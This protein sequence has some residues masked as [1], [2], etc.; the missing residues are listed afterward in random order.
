MTRYFFNISGLLLILALL[1]TACSPAPEVPSQYDPSELQFSG[2]RAYEIEEEFVTTHINRVSGSEESRLAV[3]W[4]HDQLTDSGWICEVDEWETVLYSETVELRNVVCRLPGASD[5]EILV[6]AHHDI[7]P[8]TVQGAD[9]DGSGVAILL[10][11]AEIFA[12]E[13]TPQ[14]TLVFVADDAEEFGMIG[15]R[16]YV[17]THPNPEKIIAG[18]SLDNLGR[19]YY[20]DMHTDLIGQYEGYAPIWIGLTAREAAQAAGADWE[21]ILKG[22]IDQVLNQAITISFT[23]Q[24]PINA[25]GV[26]AIGFSAGVPAEF[27]DI[28]YECWH[29]PCDNM[30]FQNP[31]SLEQ[32]GIITEALIRQLLA[33]ET[34]PEGSGP[35]LYFDGSGQMFS[36]FPLYLIFI[37]FVS[38]FFVGSYFTHRESLA[39]KSRGW[40]KALP[41]FLGLWLP[42]VASILLL[43]LFVAVGIM[44]EFTSYPGTTKD[45]TQL[46][47]SWLAVILF[48]IGV[49]VFFIIGRWLVGRFAGD[50]TT[51]EFGFTKS[52][53]FLIIGLISLVILIIDPFAL[54]FFIP[55]L[56]WFLIRGR[57]GAGKILDVVFFLLGGL[58]IYALIYFFGFMILR[59]EFVFLWYFMS[60]ISTGMFSFVDVASGAAVMAAG[61]SM[62]V[63]PPYRT[64]LE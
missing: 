6:L 47:P 27:S 42:L 20:E 21:V 16:R 34:F 10:H 63:K 49:G 62:I 46:N 14:Y 60:A 56:F 58:M 64:K 12:A 35:Y 37:G 9:N 54:I 59:Y 19:T 17:E 11:L 4:L 50:A 30:D 3:E 61:L 2:E 23:D 29:H 7:A 39:E 33:M 38:I 43:Y 15:S 41:H 13:G 36:G 5:Q 22:P 31:A 45:L 51:P 1:I 52:L 8:T 24:G 53:A 28:H 57:S 32:S 25:A 26:P 48:L 55:V 18:I 44:Q 40:L